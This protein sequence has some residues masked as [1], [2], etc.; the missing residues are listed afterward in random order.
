M[1][2]RLKTFVF[3]PL[4]MLILINAVWVYE[5][6]ASAISLL[7]FAAFIWVMFFRTFRSQIHMWN[8]RGRHCEEFFFADQIGFSG[9]FMFGVVI[10]STVKKVF[11]LNQY[12]NGCKGSNASLQ[13]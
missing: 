5:D 3:W 2:L 10:V 4:I 11:R 8:Y 9:R 12:T 13:L 6:R 7:L 1:A